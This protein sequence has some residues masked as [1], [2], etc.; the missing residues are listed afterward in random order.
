MNIPLRIV[1]AIALHILILCIFL[2]GDFRSLYARLIVLDVGQGDAVLLITKEGRTILFDGGPD[3]SILRELPKYLP[4]FQ[5][6]IDIVFLTHPHADHLDGLLSVLQGYS[7]GGVVYTDVLYNN[8]NYQL[9]KKELGSKGVPM[10]EANFDEDWYLSENVFVDVLFPFVSLHNIS[11]KN[12]NN[13]SIVAMLHVK[14]FTCL[15]A[16]DAENELESILNTFY[17][18]KLNADCLKAGHHGSKTS[19]LAAFLQNVQPDETFVSVGKDN[20]FGH[21]NPGTLCQLQIWGPVKR[22]DNDGTIVR[23]LLQ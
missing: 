21:P 17:G 22:T 2:I 1:L 10:F 20:T 3:R 13:S 14:D 6:R 9:L 4:F 7:I 16:G 11:F 18:K 23:F 8:P 5:R 15:L 19:S 12:V